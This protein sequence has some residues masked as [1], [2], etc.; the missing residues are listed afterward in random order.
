MLSDRPEEVA[1]P[2][3]IATVV[4]QS[5]EISFEYASRVVTVA[6]SSPLDVFWFVPEPRDRDCHARNH[7]RRDLLDLS[8]VD[9]DDGGE[10]A[11]ENSQPV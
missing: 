3:V 8:V 11:V 4:M 9:L 7:L 2:S 5:I 1:T 6:R 10:G